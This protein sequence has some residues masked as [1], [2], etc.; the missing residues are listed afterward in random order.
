MAKFTYQLCVP[1]IAYA[2]NITRII[3]TTMDSCNKICYVTLSKTHSAVKGMLKEY[4]I[5]INHKFLFIDAISSSIFEA[6]P[7]KN[8]IF[9]SQPLNL[10]AFEK[11]IKKAVLK[12]KVDALVFDSVSALTIYNDQKEIIQFLTK[13][14]LWL[15]KKKVISIFI[16][17]LEDK[18]KDI[19]KNL[20]M[21]VDMYG[22]FG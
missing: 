20:G 7:E 21:T 15:A 17:L 16:C 2:D 22:D 10:S 1:A 4:D 6:K 18:N 9:L 11:A 13:M 8:V 5:S 3:K 14:S 12:E 19:I